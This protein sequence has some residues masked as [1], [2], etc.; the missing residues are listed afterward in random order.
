MASG[1]CSAV[2]LGSMLS[3]AVLHYQQE[4]LGH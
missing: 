1:G 2:W 4:L 3:S